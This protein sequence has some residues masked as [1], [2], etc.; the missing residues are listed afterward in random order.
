[1][2]KTKRK[3]RTRYTDEQ[4]AKILAAA[5]REHLTAK[6]VQKRFGVTPVTYYSW[7]KKSGAGQRRGGQR[8][9][10]KPGKGVLGT[11]VRGAVQARI[12]ALL[13][14]LVEAEVNRYL[15]SLFGPGGRRRG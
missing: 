8:A 10:G 11:A 12:R 13:P 9:V 15:D 4:R 3:Q 7:R 6:D 1:M 2:A 5:K 14:G